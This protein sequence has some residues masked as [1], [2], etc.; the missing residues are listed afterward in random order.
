M[1]VLNKKALVDEVA[2]ATGFTKKDCSI[3][4]DSV[5]A[6]VSEELGKGNTVDINGFGKFLVKERSARTGVNPATGAKLEIPA[7]TVPTF[8]ASKTLKNNVK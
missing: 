1:V 3:V 7:T 4:V 8:K 6:V 2:E 5:F